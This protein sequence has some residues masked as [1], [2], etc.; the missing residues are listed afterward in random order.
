MAPLFLLILTLR[1][2]ARKHRRSP[3]NLPFSYSILAATL[4]ILLMTKRMGH[5]EFFHE[6]SKA[7]EHA[8]DS[9]VADRER[10]KHLFRL[11]DTRVDNVSSRQAEAFRLS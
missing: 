6:W 7:V 3:R 8:V 5:L 1:P 11:R 9:V 2:I 4:P 10:K